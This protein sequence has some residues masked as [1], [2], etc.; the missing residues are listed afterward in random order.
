MEDFFKSGTA[1][2]NAGVLGILGIAVIALA[3]VV[4]Q[5]YQ[6]EIRRA[7]TAL[8]LAQSATEQFERALDL[9]EKMNTRRRASD[10]R[11]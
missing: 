10:E 2:A 8:A 7:D 9:I 6:R 3:W 1:L 11:S 4:Y 5:A